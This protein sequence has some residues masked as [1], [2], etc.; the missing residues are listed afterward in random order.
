MLKLV[1]VGLAVAVPSMAYGLRRRQPTYTPYPDTKLATA[2]TSRPHS[3]MSKV[4]AA[5]PGLAA[6]AD[7]DEQQ[8]R[9]R[10]PQFLLAQLLLL[11]SLLYGGILYKPASAPVFSCICAVVCIAVMWRFAAVCIACCSAFAEPRGGAIT[12]YCKM[13]QCICACRARLL[14]TTMT[15]HHNGQSNKSSSTASSSLSP[16]RKACTQEPTIFQASGSRRGKCC[17]LLHFCRRLAHMLPACICHQLTFCWAAC[18]NFTTTPDVSSIL[19]ATQLILSR[20]GKHQIAWSPY[21]MPCKSTGSYEEQ[22]D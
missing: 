22:Y 2:F 12:T 5:Q 21:C 11:L 20:I 6:M 18:A 7:H 16:S 19:S 8:Q 15:Q 3:Q 17:P 13:H 9:T 1:A 14:V 10:D 4:D